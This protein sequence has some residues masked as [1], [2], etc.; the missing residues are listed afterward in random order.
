MS[1][2]SDTLNEILREFAWGAVREAIAGR[3]RGSVCICV[4]ELKA[5]S[6]SRG[7]SIVQ[8]IRGDARYC[9]CC[10]SQRVLEKVLKAYVGEL[11]RPG[12]WLISLFCHVRR[13]KG[14]MHLALRVHTRHLRLGSEVRVVDLLLSDAVVVQAVEGCDEKGTNGGQEY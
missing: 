14:W 5:R 1:Y 8:R 3:K 4:V 9:Y 7:R 6:D 10:C 13:R 2:C 11:R 12:M